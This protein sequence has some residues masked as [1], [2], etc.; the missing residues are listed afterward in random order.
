MKK[1]LLIILSAACI[2]S[3][4]PLFDKCGTCHGKKGE[5]HSLNLTKPIAGMKSDDL[6]KILTEY[7]AGKRNSYGFGKMMNGQ[8]S[9]LSDDDIKEVATYIESFP[10]VKEISKPKIK[11]AK[12]AEEIFK[13]CAVCHGEKAE[14][15]SL[16][17]SKILAGLDSKEIIYD[18]KEYK[19]GKRSI[20]GRGNMMRGQTSKLSDKEIELVGNYISTFAPIKVD[21][22]IIPE[23]KRKIT[24]EELDYNT[25]MDAYFRD[26]KD[27]NET[28]EA[29]KKSYKEHLNLKKIKEKNE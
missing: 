2:A 10:P 21:E 3:A 19:A 14:K 4:T 16:G 29:A 18:L 7:K 24:Q 25:F 1:S 11:K 8:T 13:K 23:P 27:P 17:V 15:K 26:S 12:S 6:I 20:Y 5:R 28:F 9:K 22:T